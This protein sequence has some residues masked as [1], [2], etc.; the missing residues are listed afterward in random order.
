MTGGLEGGL[1]N[2]LAQTRLPLVYFPVVLFS[3][4][5]FDKS[6]TLV[7][8]PNGKMGINVEHS[9]ADAPIVGHMWEV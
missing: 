7:S 9:W 5:W 4:R 3:R 8:Y 2:R 6:F 1:G